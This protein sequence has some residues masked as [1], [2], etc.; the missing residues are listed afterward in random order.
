MN[1]MVKDVYLKRILDLKSRMEKERSFN[2]GFIAG[3]K[4]QKIEILL[5]MYD[6]GYDTKEISSIIG[7]P[8]TEVKQTINEY[9]LRK[10][11]GINAVPMNI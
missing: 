4:S 5:V 9:E 3:E 7:L 11:S 8:E 6:K 1:I 10:K 2:K